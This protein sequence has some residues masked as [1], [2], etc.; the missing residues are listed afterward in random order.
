[1]RILVVSTWYPTRDAPFRTPFITRHV[2]AISRDHDVHVIHVQLLDGSPVTLENYDGVAVT[3]VGF[4]PRK[5][6]TMVKALAEIR[7]WARFSDVVHTMAFSS[8]LIAAPVVGRTPW[9]HTEHW[10]GLLFPGHVNQ[11]WERT[12]WLRH[13]LRLPRVVTGVSTLMTRKLEEF[14]R[15]GATALIGNVVDYAP[16]VASP[17]SDSALRLIGVGA[18]T[19]HKGA[20]LAVDTVAWLREQGH[21]ASLVWDG[22]GPVR[23]Q[24]QE[25][26]RELGIHDHVDFR[27]FRGTED[28]WRDLA[29]ST[30]FML[31]SKSE[32]FCVAAAEALAAGRPVIMGDRGGQGDF[33]TDRNGRMVSERTPEAFGRAVL[34]LSQDSVKA[35]PE[36]MARG[37]RAR[38]GSDAVSDQLTELY[39]SAHGGGRRR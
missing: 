7:H 5:P 29:E 35:T 20:L 21:E 16:Q 13:V 19:E 34:D 27:G 32:T 24:A 9:V 6:L 14:A 1:M 2:R 26:A 17:P 30:I 28:L 18:A 31:P 37:I 3:R 12:A 15:P 10:N 36:E 8:A 11:L 25:R 38:Y 33:I 23:E 22:D 39:R 4:D